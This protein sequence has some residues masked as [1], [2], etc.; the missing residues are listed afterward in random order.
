MN[1]Q[2]LE[3]LEIVDG[4][5]VVDEGKSCLH[6]TSQG[7]VAGRSKQGIQPDQP[8]AGTAQARDFCAQ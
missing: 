1:R 8:V 6:A 2:R 4:Q 7:L 3:A 5:K